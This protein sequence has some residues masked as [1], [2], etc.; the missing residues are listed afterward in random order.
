MTRV[1]N[2]GPIRWPTPG[3]AWYGVFVLMLGGLVGIM[4][5]QI[6]NLVVEPVRSSL[7]L[8]D[9]QI[10][11]LQ[12]LAFTLFYMVLGFPIGWLVDRMHRLRLTGIGVAILGAGTLGCGLAHSFD[13]M[14]VSR[15]LI[16]IGEAALAPAA[17]SLIADYFSPL[18]RPVA[19]SVYGAYE[20]GGA[21]LSLLA[22][23]IML[24]VAGTLQR[25]P[26]AGFA[27]LEPWRF[28]FIAA[29]IPAFIVAV[30]LV[31]ADEPLRRND[32]DESAQGEPGE[33]RRS[34]PE[35]WVFLR[36]ARG[37]IVPHILGLSV[38]ASVS[39]GLLNWMPTILI[40][41]YGWHAQ[42]IGFTLGMMFLALGPAGTLSAGYITR[43][44]Q[45]RGIEDAALRAA[46]LGTLVVC[47]AVA[48]IALPWSSRTIL[49]PIGVAVFGTSLTPMVS[50]VAIQHATP[51]HLRGR[52][53]AIYY[54]ATGIAAG[55]LGPLIPALLTQYAFRSTAKIGESLAIF[56]LVATPLAVAVLSASL[57]PYRRLLAQG[58]RDSTSPR[59]EPEGAHT[60]GRLT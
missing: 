16:G 6:F 26:I 10:G 40:R 47:A 36:R 55:N 44:W 22:G 34:A 49:V 37:W 8:T 13:A 48:S 32:S 51:A 2:C 53:S 31:T 54:L 24:G 3:V 45:R 42:D 20:M 28:V 52:I 23:G 33:I 17:V 35:F 5:H 39:M 41:D 19:M 56:G 25:A 15:S 46:C 27:T 14:F 21:G 11:V 57:A 43:A 60:D 9:V 7:G 1:A 30:V 38:V 50:I 58:A 12:G 4:D 18:Q 59:V 29:A